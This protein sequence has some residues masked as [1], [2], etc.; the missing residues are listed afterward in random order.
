MA[1]HK[2]YVDSSRFVVVKC[3]VINAGCSLLMQPAARRDVQIVSV[4]MISMNLQH[5]DVRE[6]GRGDNC[7]GTEESPFKKWH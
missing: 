1:M 7:F 3:I 5:V 4:M 6:I 2:S